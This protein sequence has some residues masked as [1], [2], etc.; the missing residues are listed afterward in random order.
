LTDHEVYPDPPPRP[1][2]VAES[3]RIAAERM[4]LG[5]GLVV[6]VETLTWAGEG[7]RGEAL[8]R[9]PDVTLCFALIES[10]PNRGFLCNLPA[11]SGTS[12]AG[13]GLC[14]RHGGNTERGNREGAW[15]VA[16]A[17]ARALDV[18]P[19]EGLLTAV[20]IAAGKVAFCEQKLA[21]AEVDRQL[22]PP[23]E[24]AISEAGRT[25]DAQGT[26]MHYWVK[27][28]ELWH[29]KLAR[30]SQM[31]IQSGVAERLVRQVE[32]EAQLMLRA[33][34]LTFEELGLSEDVRERALGIMSRKLL[35]LEAAET[36][37]ERVDDR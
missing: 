37:E 35:E 5:D 1:W 27:Q 18:T 10:G 2:E 4:W 12:H 14:Y 13:V 7:Q 6:D 8:R 16:H 24:N 11:G 17:F 22:E 29:D 31:A 3:W 25:H 21:Q 32:L 30:V 15:I 33:T 19:W 23:S 26:N 20:K 28:S 36:S 9:N 34:S